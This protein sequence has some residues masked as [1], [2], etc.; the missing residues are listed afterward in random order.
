MMEYPLKYAQICMVLGSLFQAYA[1]DIAKAVSISHCLES[2]IKLQC[3]KLT[4]F[5]I[6]SLRINQTQ[7]FSHTLTPAERN[8]I[9]RA[10]NKNELYFIR[11]KL[12][13]ERDSTYIQS[14]C[15]ATDIVD[16]SFVLGVILNVDAFG[17]P[18]AVEVGPVDPADRRLLLLPEEPSDG[19]LLGL[20]TVLGSQSA[21]TP[22]V[23]GYRKKLQREQAEKK[24]AESSDN[25]S[26]LSKYWMYIV[27][28]VLFMLFSG[29]MQGGPQGGG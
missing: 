10:S 6:Q 21:P 26:F 28:V 14:F 8:Q 13:N 23:E 9:E 29:G 20:V 22:D 25:R 12:D 16:S 24:A 17:R 27:P 15:K 3:E 2:E 11:A 5:S 18:Y 4:E 19:T 1:Q 7:T